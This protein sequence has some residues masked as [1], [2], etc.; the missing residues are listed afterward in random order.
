[1][2][3]DGSALI[4]MQFSHQGT[5]GPLL[6]AFCHQLQ[7]WHLFSSVGFFEAHDLRLSRDWIEHGKRLIRGA[8]SVSNGISPRRYDRSCFSEHPDDGI[9]CLDCE[10][11]LEQ[12][13]TT[14]L[15]MLKHYHAILNGPD[16]SLEQLVD[17]L[18][19]F[20]GM[21]IVTEN[22]KYFLE[23]RWTSIV[24]QRNAHVLDGALHNMTSLLNGRLRL[25]F[26][27]VLVI[28]EELC[29]FAECQ[30][31]LRETAFG[32]KVRNDLPTA[33]P[34]AKNPQEKQLHEIR[35]RTMWLLLRLDQIHERLG[36]HTVGVHR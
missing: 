17:E 14:W 3:K 13:R 24:L 15:N 8:Q 33:L 4:L 18:T 23:K 21:H 31:I 29:S 20:M 7:R 27:K 6:P 22:L 12:L 9:A 30:D 28:V 34:D 10:E 1:M 16:I 25:Q 5:N 26:Q 36:E 19:I 11:C 2:I 32:L 35:S